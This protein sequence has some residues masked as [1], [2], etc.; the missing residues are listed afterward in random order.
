[1]APASSAKILVLEDDVV[2][3]LDYCLLFEDMGYETRSC[4]RIAEAFDAIDQEEI[5]FALVDHQL[6]GRTS[7][8]VRRQ[9]RNMKIPFIIVSGSP[10]EEFSS[11]DRRH[12]H[13]KPIPRDTIEKALKGRTRVAHRNTRSAT[14]QARKQS[15]RV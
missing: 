9:L 11:L 12:L 14:T 4:Y 3:N 7:E 6:A 15:A 2:V 8:E 5:V 1:M 10:E 13:Q